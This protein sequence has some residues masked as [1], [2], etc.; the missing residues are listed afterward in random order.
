MSHVWELEATALGQ[1]ALAAVVLGAGLPALFALGIR[2][3]AWGRGGAAE[4]SGAPAHPGGRAL[5][6]VVFAVVVLVALLGLAFIVASG[7]G[8][9][10]SFEHVYPTIVEK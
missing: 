8:Y 10:L 4:A 1:I 2:A 3:S 7:S 9:A 5:S 6:A